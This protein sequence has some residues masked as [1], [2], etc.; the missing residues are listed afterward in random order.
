MFSP[1]NEYKMY[2]LKKGKYRKD[3]ETKAF[4]DAHLVE[5]PAWSLG[6]RSYPPDSRDVYT[7]G[8]T[9]DVRK[10]GSY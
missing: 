2:T 10:V 8:G 6:S 9:H 4:S 5:A 3:K 1:K 7:E